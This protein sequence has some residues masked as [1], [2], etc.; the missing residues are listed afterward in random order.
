MPMTLNYLESL[1]ATHHIFIGQ[2]D[3]TFTMVEGSLRLESPKG[4]QIDLHPGE[5]CVVKAGQVHSFTNISNASARIRTQIIPGN[6][7]FENSLRIRYGLATT[8]P[9]TRPKMS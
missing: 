1:E 6:K 9:T 3:E 2:Y 8:P 5:K 4:V 7:G